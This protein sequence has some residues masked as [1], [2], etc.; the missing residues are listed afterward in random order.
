MS[1]T[2]F[3]TRVGC[4]FSLEDYLTVRV[5]EHCDEDVELGVENDDVPNAI[6]NYVN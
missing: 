1:W 2:N 3:I 6:D 4:S 5:P